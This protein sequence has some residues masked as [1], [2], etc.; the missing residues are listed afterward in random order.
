MGLPVTP[1]LNISQEAADELDKQ[2][3]N[4]I[5]ADLGL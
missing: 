3:L 1:D 4:C 2:L 5:N